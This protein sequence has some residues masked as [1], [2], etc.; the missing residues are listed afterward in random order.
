MK[1]PP[2]AE[3]GYDTSLGYGRFS[4]GEKTLTLMSLYQIDALQTAMLNHPANNFNSSALGRYQIVR[5]TL[6]GLR[7]GSDCR[8]ASFIRPSCRIAWGWR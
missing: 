8:E 1:E 6:R 7:K 3:S 4:G 2:K 5:K